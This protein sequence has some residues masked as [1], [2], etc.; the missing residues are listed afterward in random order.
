MQHIINTILKVTLLAFLCSDIS[1]YVSGANLRS[2][3]KL[4]NLDGVHYTPS[5]GHTEEEHTHEESSDD[6]GVPSED[7]PVVEASADDPVV[8]ASADDPVVHA[9]A[10]DLIGDALAVVE[11]AEEA[12]EAVEE[13]VEETIGKYDIGG[14]V[15]SADDPVVP[16]SA[17]D[18]IVEA[19]SDDAATVVEASSDDA[20]AVVEA[21]SDDAADI[22]PGAIVVGFDDD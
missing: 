5:A 20:A 2:V 19:S 15:A 9:S 10:D 4:R 7:D 11:A 12:L 16:A 18:P 17:D 6:A 21:S 13:A 3:S 1:Q 22:V 8:E 14:D